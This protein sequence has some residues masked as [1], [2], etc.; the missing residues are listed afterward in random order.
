MPTLELLEKLKSSNYGQRMIKLGH[1]KGYI[2]RTHVKV[3]EGKKGNVFVIN[4]LTAKGKQKVS[5][6]SPAVVRACP[7]FTTHTI[8]V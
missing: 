6:L 5:K 8:I 4:R 3:S 1:K 7:G 2:E